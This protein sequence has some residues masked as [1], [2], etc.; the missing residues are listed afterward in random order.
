MPVRKVSNT[1]LT[2]ILPV[3]Q[4]WHVEAGIIRSPCISVLDLGYF[5]AIANVAGSFWQKLKKYFWYSKTE[6]LFKL[7]GFGR[8]PE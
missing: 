8:S 5:Y 3:V 7:L 4:K 2:A 6:K 1:P